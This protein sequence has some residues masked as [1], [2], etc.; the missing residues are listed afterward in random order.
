MCGHSRAWAGGTL[1]IESDSDL[2]EAWAGGGAVG[3]HSCHRPPIVFNLL[4]NINISPTLILKDPPAVCPQL[5]ISV[6][7]QEPHQQGHVASLLFEVCV[8]KAIGF[9]FLFY[10]YE[11]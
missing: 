5:K 11:S 8:V 7:F 10:E 4:K 3:A 1:V 6:C 9:Q 2:G